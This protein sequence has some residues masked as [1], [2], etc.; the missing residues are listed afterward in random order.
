MGMKPSPG[1]LFGLASGI[2]LAV[3]IVRHG[4]IIQRHGR[5][6]ADLADQF[7]IFEVEQIIVGRD[8]EAT[9]FASAR[10]AE[11]KQL[12]PGRGAQSQGLR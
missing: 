11:V 5:H 7:D 9:D 8:A 4:L 2:H 1:E 10:I 12:G 3:K 6:V